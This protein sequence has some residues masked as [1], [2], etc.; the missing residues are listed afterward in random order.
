MS[1][2]QILEDFATGSSEWR[3]IETSPLVLEDSASSFRL[4]AEGD[5]ELKVSL[6]N[7]ENAEKVAQEFLATLDESSYE[8]EGQPSGL[9]TTEGFSAFVD[10]EC[11]DDEE[12]LALMIELAKKTIQKHVVHL[13]KM[14]EGVSQSET[15][16]RAS[17]SSSS[18]ASSSSHSRSENIQSEPKSAGNRHPLEAVVQYLE[19]KNFKYTDRR[20]ESSPRVLLHM[21]T[22]KYVDGDGDSALL[23]RIG[24]DDDSKML[25][26]STPQMY[27]CF[28]DF[29]KTDLAKR[30]DK[31]AKV[32]TLLGYHQYSFKYIRYAF[33][34]RD[35]ELRFELDFPV[36]EAAIHDSQIQL[37]ISMLVQLA[38]HVYADWE[39]VL[40]QDL[41]LNGI[42]EKWM[43]EE[44]QSYDSR[45]Q[46]SDIEELIGDL[47]AEQ[48]QAWLARAAALVDDIKSDSGGI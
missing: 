32:S 29:E 27:W 47:S 48:K 2:E 14:L 39:S 26:F 33:D 4:Q 6:V 38:D 44:I 36:K 21:K 40:K 17:S 25:R 37:H 42:F 46:L 34:P 41:S 43:K 20:E 35:G 15:S 3:A 12:N 18:T 5:C 30:V 19:S 1:I 16:S 31:I 23:I 10:T 8:L 11:S 45:Q 24:Y 13:G 7:D 9:V 28:Q 22:D